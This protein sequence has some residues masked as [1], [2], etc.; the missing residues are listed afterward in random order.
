MTAALKKKTQGLSRHPVTSS[1]LFPF[2]PRLHLGFWSVFPAE[3]TRWKH[4]SKLMGSIDSK[5]SGGYWW[6]LFS[7]HICK[8]FFPIKDS[9]TTI[10]HPI[11]F[12][13]HHLVQSSAFQNTHL[14]KKNIYL[15]NKKNMSHRTT[16][17]ANFGLWMF[18]SST[19]LNQSH[20]PW[21]LTNLPYKTVVG[22]TIILSSW[23]LAPFF[24]GSP[25]LRFGKGV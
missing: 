11:V 10:D 5:W 13:D 16:A 14:Y 12:S 18:S 20:Q 9:Y 6:F 24:K 25:F 2:T 15:L 19:M 4:H 23:V 21:K 17:S 1:H 3:K 8:L 7:R 22:N